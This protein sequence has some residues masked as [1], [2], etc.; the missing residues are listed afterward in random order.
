[1][2]HFAQWPTESRLCCLP[3][4]TGSIQSA[5]AVTHIIDNKQRQ[6]KNPPLQIAETVF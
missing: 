3:D 5:L 4:A 1:M 6:W 2:T